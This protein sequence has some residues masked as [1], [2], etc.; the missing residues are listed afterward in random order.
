MLSER[1]EALGTCWALGG[2][3]VGARGPTALAGCWELGQECSHAVPQELLGPVVFPR[4]AE[5]Q[6]GR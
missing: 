5:Q 1:E 4:Q 2:E 6:S 3:G